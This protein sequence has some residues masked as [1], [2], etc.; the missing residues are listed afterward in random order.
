M[1]SPVRPSRVRWVVRVVQVDNDSILEPRFIDPTFLECLRYLGFAN[2]HDVSDN[3]KEQRRN[4]FDLIAPGTLNQE[5]T[6]QWADRQA[7][8]MRSFGYNAVPCPTNQKAE[9]LP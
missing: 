7:S 8:R 6:K 1:K 9:L 3:D 4:C 5:Q 2:V